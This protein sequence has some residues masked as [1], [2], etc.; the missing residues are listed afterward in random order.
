[1]IVIGGINNDVVYFC[2]SKIVDYL[3]GDCFGLICLALVGGEGGVI[4]LGLGNYYFV[5]IGS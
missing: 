5:I 4:I 1:M 2:I 3:F